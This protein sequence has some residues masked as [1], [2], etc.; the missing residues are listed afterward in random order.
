M[1]LLSSRQYC[2][3]TGGYR[4]RRRVRAKNRCTPDFCGVVS[5]L[6]YYTPSTGRW[7]SRDPQGEFTQR[8]L[9]CA[10]GNDGI[11][12]FDYL[13]LADDTL[14]KKLDAVLQ[15]LRALYKSS[16][17]ATA[18]GFD[19]SIVELESVL[20][21]PRLNIEI[22]PGKVGTANDAIFSML[23]GTLYLRNDFPNGWT[24]AHELVHADINFF[25]P[26]FWS[27]RRHEGA[28]YGYEE[29][30]NEVMSAIV[31]GP[32]AIAN[33][34]GCN[35]DAMRKSWRGFWSRYS[36]PSHL[37]GGVYYLTSL[38]PA[39]SFTFDA[40]DFANTK[41]VTKLGL[42]CAT[43]A[44]EINKLLEKKHCCYKVTCSQTSGS[45]TEIPAGAIINPVFQ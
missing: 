13:G 42:S 41:S 32:E 6:R 24:L 31:A 8:N 9:Y 11:N 38:G 4:R 28:A 20:L 5:G 18:L 44:A 25:T 21:S 23:T 10:F 45:Q 34:E 15:N 39:V 30:G 27:P 37:G 33:Q 43:V 17:T 7:L 19:E 40:K 29:M 26:G 22:N 36:Q 1:K 16:P 35:Y 14:I 12:H 2:P 3:P